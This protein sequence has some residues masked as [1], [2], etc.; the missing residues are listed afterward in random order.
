MVSATSWKLEPPVA[1]RVSRQRDKWFQHIF[2]SSDPRVPL[3]RRFAGIQ[4]QSPTAQVQYEADPYLSGWGVEKIVRSIQ[5]ESSFVG[6][7]AGFH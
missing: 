3:R 4:T 7:N 2:K 5:A 6:D 1:W